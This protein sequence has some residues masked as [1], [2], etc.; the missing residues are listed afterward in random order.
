MTTTTEI[1]KCTYDEFVQRLVARGLPIVTGGNG[2]ITKPLFKAFRVYRVAYTHEEQ[3]RVNIPLHTMY[4]SVVQDLV[5][6]AYAMFVITNVEKGKFQL[7]VRY[8][9]LTDKHLDLLCH[10]LTEILL[11]E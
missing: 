11:I 1:C 7:G 9:F 10:T 5:D 4:F 8:W 2:I 3:P 6:R